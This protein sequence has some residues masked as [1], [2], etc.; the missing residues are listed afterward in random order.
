MPLLVIAFA[1]AAFVLAGNNALL[2]DLRESN[3]ADAV[4]VLVAN[5][6]GSRSDVADIWNN[7]HWGERKLR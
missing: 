7:R 6:D 3:S 5:G 4:E 1:V 2:T